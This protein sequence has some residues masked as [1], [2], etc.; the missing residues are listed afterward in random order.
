MRPRLL[1]CV[2]FLVLYFLQIV[3]CAAD[4]QVIRI[5]ATPYNPPFESL[6]NANGGFAGF[7]VEILNEVCKRMQATCMY[8]PI[9]AY[10]IVDALTYGEIDI[11]ITGFTKPQVVTQNNLI[12]SLSY[13]PSY[14]QFMVLQSS[15]IKTSY[16]LNNK[17]IGI[18][19]TV[20]EPI[21]SFHILLQNLYHGSITLKDDYIT[22]DDLINA[23]N[24][25]E[26]YAVLAN[27]ATLAYWDNN[28]PGVYKLLDKPIDTL[29]G[30]R[31]ISTTPNM[32]LM[33]KINHT[34]ITMFEDGSWKSIYDR[35]FM[36]Q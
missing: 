16:E 26:V 18:R 5:G 33:S 7:E 23:L 17:I 34:L 30:Y 24:K 8:K 2:M 29:V 13:A 19:K 12:F 20:I 3:L 27:A 28:N 1:S 14:A 25:G 4:T 11:A 22:I 32:A 21:S 35:Y 15:N 9:L 6:N 31:V 36:I 10:D